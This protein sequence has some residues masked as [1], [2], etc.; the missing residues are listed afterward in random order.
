MF[1]AL[2]AGKAEVPGGSEGDVHLLSWRGPEPRF[3]VSVCFD[4]FSFWFVN[5][6]DLFLNRYLQLLICHWSD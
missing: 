6:D 1:E 5:N 4:C 2:V 3:E